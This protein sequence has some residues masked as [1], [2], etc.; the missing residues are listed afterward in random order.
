MAQ[1]QRKREDAWEVEERQ[2]RMAKDANERD[3][4]RRLQR[5]R[6]EQTILKQKQQEELLREQQSQV[7]EPAEEK[8]VPNNVDEYEEEKNENSDEELNEQENTVRSCQQNEWAHQRTWKRHEESV[9]KKQDGKTK[10]RQEVRDSVADRQKRNR[11]ELIEEMRCIGQRIDI[12][13]RTTELNKEE[14]AELDD[15]YNESEQEI[16]DFFPSIQEN[17][18]RVNN[19]LSSLSISDLYESDISI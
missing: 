9:N 3:E 5:Q 8:Q 6:E 13:L 18:D 19:N 1:R 16:R 11:Q 4:Y 15:H 7:N 2:K 10:N 12:P 17:E 14:V